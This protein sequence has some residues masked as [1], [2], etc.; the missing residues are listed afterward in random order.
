[1]KFFNYEIAAITEALYTGI[2]NHENAMGAWA[3]SLYY[4][5]MKSLGNRIP[6]PEWEEAYSQW[7]IDHLY[8][9]AL[10]SK[11][12]GER[13]LSAEIQSVTK[14]RNALLVK[15]QLTGTKKSAFEI[16]LS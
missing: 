11:N 2:E 4:A 3:F 13:N 6:A 7:N 16:S 8:R 12:K 15:G 1:M 10:S 9:G 5:I 14:K